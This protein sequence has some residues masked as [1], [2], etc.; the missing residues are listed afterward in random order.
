MAQK[1]SVNQHP[2]NIL[3]SWIQSGE[4][5]IPEIQRPMV[6]DSIKV[7]DLMD[8]LYQGFPVGY[9]IIWRNPS[10]RLKNGGISQGKRI[11]IDGQQRISALRAA[12][13]G[14]S[15]INDE[16]KEVKIKISFNPLT[17]QFATQ[18]PATLKDVVWIPDISELVKNED[19]LS[20]VD[21]Y[22][23]KNPS[24]DRKLIGANIQKLLQIK[25]VQ[26]GVIELAEELDIETV[27]NIF[28][29]I[30]SKGVVLSQADFA[31]SKIASHD[32]FGVNLRKLIDYFC[33]LSHEPQ[34]YKQISQNDHDFSETGYLEKIAWLKDVNDDLYD[35][36][37]SDVLRASFNS[38]FKRGRMQDLVSLLSGRNFE[39]RS[40]E[41]NIVDESF[42]LLEKG[43]LQYVN[44][45]NFEKFLMIV[46]SSGFISNDLINSQNSLNYA[47]AIYLYLRSL[48]E[49][50][51]KIEKIVRKWFVLSALTGRYT[52][53]HET[54]FDE[55][56]R[57]IEGVGAEQ[58][59]QEIEDSNLSEVFWN[60]SLPREL[61]K[62]IIT[63]PYLKAY[64]ASQV[65]FNDEGF[66]S[67]DIKVREM[68]EHRGDVHH[69]FPKNYLKKKFDSSNVYN[70][71]ANYV[72]AQQDINI[73]IGDKS[74]DKY[75]HE[76]LEQCI[77]KKPVYG[78]I[79]D[80][81]DLM[82][83]LQKH[84]IPE[85]IFDMTIDNYQDFLEQRRFLMAKKI[86]NFYKSL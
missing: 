44:Q 11:L 79:I 67:K 75:F 71:V 37:Y 52:S 13:L 57:R 5:A 68:I 30:N 42:S 6:W 69:L 74:P 25:N 56:I 41:E 51:S 14:E 3:L 19:L 62:S 70:Q 29:R 33:H 27:T 10:V 4:I 64:F 76:V 7:R 80:K 9:I 77:S 46:K 86:E 2:I 48:G 34:F 39:T 73:K 17:E 18:T 35:P 16:Y 1:Y 50:P 24:A 21:S 65:Y 58:T 49:N 26:I 60:T 83:N 22:M 84:C 59:L 78:N 40:Y 15:I 32:D 47:Y 31:M 63:S 53:S 43:V 8:S 72:Y 61:D 38:S 82:E 55:D 81:K 54:I 20:F 45:T 28:I 36:D 23:E 12:I 66:L 85:S